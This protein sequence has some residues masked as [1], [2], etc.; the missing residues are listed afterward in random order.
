[1]KVSLN[2]CIRSHPCCVGD[3]GIINLWEVC[4]DAL[5]TASS[6]HS[7]FKHRASAPTT[8]S[9]S[10]S[11]PWADMVGDE[12]L[13]EELRDYF[14]YMQLQQRREGE[15]SKPLT[16]PY[17]LPGTVPA[18]ALPM[19]MQAAGYYPSQR[20]VEDLVAHVK[21]LGGVTPAASNPASAVGGARGASAGKLAGE[22]QPLKEMATDE[23]GLVAGE[24]IAASSRCSSKGGS[25]AQTAES[26]ASSTLGRFSVVDPEQ[27]HLQEEEDGVDFETFLYLYVNHRPVQA[28]TKQDV[29]KALGVLGAGYPGGEV[30]LCVDMRS[31]QV[32]GT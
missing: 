17:D 22:Q 26:A 13:L 12:Q 31:L 19:L 10:N 21:F 15:P 11:S 32:L 27:Q 5:N 14:T 28:V 7:S 20:E 1:M 29:V 6:R 24:A 2:Y 30:T 4:T 23:A 9:S 8:S 16:E 18:A 25:R 3:G